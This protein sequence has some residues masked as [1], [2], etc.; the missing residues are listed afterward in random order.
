M[1]LWHVSLQ[2]GG[3]L[4]GLSVPWGVTRQEGLTAPPVGVLGTPRTPKKQGD[5]PQSG[6]AKRAKPRQG[7]SRLGVGWTAAATTALLTAETCKDGHSR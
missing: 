6:D 2:R 5:N 1:R 4:I 7:T 3:F